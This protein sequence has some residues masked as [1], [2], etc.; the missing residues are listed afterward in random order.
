MYVTEVKEFNGGVLRQV[1]RRETISAGNFG[2]LA[3]AD[4]LHPQ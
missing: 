4:P 3:F 1:C 2:I